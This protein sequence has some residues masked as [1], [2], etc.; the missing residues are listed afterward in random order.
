MLRH[1][2]Q[3][4]GHAHGVERGAQNGVVYRVVDLFA[5]HVDLHLQLADGFDVLFACHQRHGKILLLCRCV[6][7]VP[8][9]VCFHDSGFCVFVKSLSDK[10]RLICRG[11]MSILISSGTSFLFW[12]IREMRSALKPST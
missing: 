12:S 2:G 3:V 11:S 5:E 4:I 10:I 7:L 8:R 9:H 6:L 1:L